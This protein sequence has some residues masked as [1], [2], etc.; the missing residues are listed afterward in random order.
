MTSTKK[1]RN[2]EEIEKLSKEK[3]KM[4][5]QLKELVGCHNL[6]KF[7]GRSAGANSVGSDLTASRG[8]GPALVAILLASDM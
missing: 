2:T 4:A 5:Q 6:S 3:E 8:S 7:L 1:Q